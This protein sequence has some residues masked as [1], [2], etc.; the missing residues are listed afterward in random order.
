MRKN[1][2]ISTYCNLIFSKPS[3]SFA[4][5]FYIFTCGCNYQVTV[6]SLT[7]FLSKLR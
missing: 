3:Y 2:R 5:V 6:M 1:K 7:K 4:H